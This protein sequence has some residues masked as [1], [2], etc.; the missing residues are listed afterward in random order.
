MGVVLLQADVSE[1]ARKLEAQEKYSGK[2]E[3][4]K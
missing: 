2:F 3:F 4:D 1:E